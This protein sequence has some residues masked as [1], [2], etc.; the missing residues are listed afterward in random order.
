MSPPAPG[1]TVPSPCSVSGD[2]SSSRDSSGLHF[3]CPYITPLGNWVNTEG[4]L[5]QLAEEDAPYEKIR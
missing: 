2:S 3:L 1:G 4:Y 5:S